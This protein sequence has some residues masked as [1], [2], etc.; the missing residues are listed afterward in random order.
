MGGGSILAVTPSIWRDLPPKRPPEKGLGMGPQTLL[1]V[2]LSVTLALGRDLPPK[3]PPVRSGERAAGEA[4]SEG[5]FSGNALNSARFTADTTPPLGEASPGKAPRPAQKGA[6]KRRF[7][8]IYKALLLF[9]R[10]RL[11]LLEKPTHTA[12]N[13]RAK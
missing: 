1:G 12:E 3:R 9:G 7:Q 13:H 4:V 6:R 2:V 8:V 11:L 5:R 10:N